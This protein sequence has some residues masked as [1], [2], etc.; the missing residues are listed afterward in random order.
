MYCKYSRQ[1]RRCGVAT[2]RNK[3]SLQ[4]ANLSYTNIQPLSVIKLQQILGIM[5]IK[6]T[7][8]VTGVELKVTAL[9]RNIRN[10]QGKVGNLRECNGR[11]LRKIA[12][13][14]GCRSLSSNLFN[15]TLQHMHIF[16][17]VINQLDAQKFCFTISLFHASTYFE[18][19]CSSSGG[20]NCIT[21]PLVSS[22]L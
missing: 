18:H 3:Q 16:I 19:M 20:Q 21:Q 7:R 5:L 15:Y 14:N 4:I 12:V 22:R 17:S 11:Y 2:L 8:D 6:E 10:T 9:N 1:R 13:L